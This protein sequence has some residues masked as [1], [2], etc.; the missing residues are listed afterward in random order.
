MKIPLRVIIPGITFAF[1]TEEVLPAEIFGWGRNQEG[2]VGNGTHSNLYEPGPVMTTPELNQ[3]AIAAMDPGFLHTLIL[4]ADGR[5]FT[6]G[7]N[8]YGNLGI[9]TNASSTVPVAVDMSGVLAGKIVTA[10]AVSERHNLVVTSDGMVYAWGSNAW[11]QLG[12]GTL[13]ERNSPVAV[14][15]SGALAGK[16]VTAVA[17]SGVLSMALTSDGRVFTWGANEHRELGDGTDVDWR[18][19]PVAVVTDGVLAGK[20]VTKIATGGF[21]ALALTSDG[22]LVSWGWNLNGQLGDGTKD[23][24]FFGAGPV[25]VVRSGALSGK[26]VTAISA[27]LFH[28]VAL[29]SD[30]EVFTWGDNYESQLGEGTTIEHTSPIAASAG[31]LNGEFITAVDA[32]SFH[33]VAV[34]SRGKLITWGRNSHGQLG[35]GTASERMLPVEVIM[36]GAMSGRSVTAIS[37]G[38]YHAIVLTDLNALG[39]WRKSQFGTASNTGNAA[40]NADPDGD[41]VPNL[42]E[43]VTGL[44]PGIENAGLLPP[45]N[46][47]EN[48]LTTTWTAPVDLTGVT[49]RAEYSPTLQSG[50]WTPVPNTAAPPLQSF[51]VPVAGMPKFFVRLRVTV[52]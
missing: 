5:L 12:D 1:W 50:G 33:N 11:G 3:M 10:I 35:D 40:D 34:T 15:M 21:H 41:T 23:G 4:T 9:G 49:V 19:E 13:D 8:L 52:P 22:T 26:T 27:G 24:Q 6:S 42:I 25:A 37:A 2:Q 20:T 45:W 43:F 47:T 31:S 46:L 14:K 16:T 36:G 32:A 39:T 18:T 48:G 44:D 51:T 28:S 29:T 7:Q 38:G 17:A 30:G